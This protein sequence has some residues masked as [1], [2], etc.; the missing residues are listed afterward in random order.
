[1]QSPDICCVKMRLA[2]I[3]NLGLKSLWTEPWLAGLA[4]TCHV[5]KATAD[6]VL[7]NAVLMPHD[8]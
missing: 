5:R 2:T 3:F 8:A 7:L 1:M 4:V 6:A